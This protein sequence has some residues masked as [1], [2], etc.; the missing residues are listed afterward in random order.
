MP[1]A[2]SQ[3]FISLFSSKS[4]VVLDV[5]YRSEI[6]FEL[7]F[8]KDYLFFAALG[9]HCYAWAFSCCSEQGI[10]FVAVHRLLIL[11]ASLVA[12]CRL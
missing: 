4:F 3:R 7:N 10:L 1:N 8:F 2:R 5:K 11:V 6:H 9:L 12:E